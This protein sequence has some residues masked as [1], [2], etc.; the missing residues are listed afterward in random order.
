MSEG[1]LEMAG[2]DDRCKGM[3]DMSGCTHQGARDVI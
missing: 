3:P 2:E 1:N